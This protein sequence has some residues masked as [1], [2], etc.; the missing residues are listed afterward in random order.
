MKAKFITLEGGEGAGKSTQMKL[1][2]ARLQAA[3]V[4]VVTTREPGGTPDADALRS[5]LVNGEPDRWS[6]AAE[7]LLNYAARDSHLTQVIRPA[8]A[9][10][11][12]VVCD[13][14]ADSTR[15]YQ[16]IAGMAGLDLVEQLDRII[17]GDTQPDLTLILDLDPAAGLERAGLRG[18]ADRFEK[19]GLAFHEVLREAFLQIARDNPDRCRVI[20]ASLP[21]DHVAGQ[22]WAAVA[23]ELAEQ[24]A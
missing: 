22:I 8:L 10:G 20:D 3:G 2:A 5:L 18:G 1:L 16:G 21:V 17:V 6:P 7:A 14:F 11:R 9:A 23:P 19:K 15:A 12:T 4:D 13:R 24:G